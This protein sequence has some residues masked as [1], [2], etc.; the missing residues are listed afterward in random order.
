MRFFVNFEVTDRIKIFVSDNDKLA[1]II[2]KNSAEI[3]NI[4]LADEIIF[5]KVQ[6]AK[7]WDINV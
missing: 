2:E 6:G 4:T 1:K 7:D 5:E 3:K